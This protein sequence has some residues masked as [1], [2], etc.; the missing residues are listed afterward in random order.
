MRCLISKKQAK[1]ARTISLLLLSFFTLSLSC[2]C[3]ETPTDADRES[4]LPVVDWTT[5][6]FDV[7]RGLN[8]G[9]WL[10]Q[11]S[12]RN[13]APERFFTK[14]EI[15]KCAEWGFDH[16]RI[17]VDEMEIF[18]ENGDWNQKHLKLLHDAMDYC[19]SQ[20][21]RVILDFHILRSHY[22]NDTEKMT[23]WKNKA[24]QDKFIAMW[25][26]I[27]AEFKDYPI[28]F[29]AYELLNE[30]VPPGPDDWNILMNRAIV[31][32]R[33]LEPERMLILDPSSHS[34][35]GQL[36]NMDIP[37]GDPNF[38]VTVHFYTPHLL[39][40]YQAAWMDGLKN[41]SIPLHYPGQLVAQADYDTIT[42]QKHKDVVRYYNG[43][44]DK[45]VLQ[46]RV[47]EAIDFAKMKNLQLHVG[48]VG[49]IDNTD[50][51]VMHA[52]YKDVLD[53]FKENNV[54]FSI[55]G[56]KSNFGILTDYGTPKDK[57]LIDIITE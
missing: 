41:L 23:L 26:K 55:W 14:N 37:E 24:E 47:Q 8:I 51:E 11:T 34:S 49:C 5:A 21:M 52:W 4:V 31:E 12:T 3:C 56:Y 36:K 9:G 10:S 33:R 46:L 29:L 48:E 19:M 18:T 32:L 2:N 28:G 16:L 38:M 1:Q 43:Y 44:Y 40:H 50:K 57:E 6:D 27:S 25:K 20:N 30:P 35:I 7:L 13:V 53:I 17:P 22:F 39:T 42:V 54:A 15:K 45:A